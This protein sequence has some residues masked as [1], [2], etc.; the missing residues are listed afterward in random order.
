MNIQ[1]PFTFSNGYSLGFGRSLG[2]RLRAF[3]A[4]AGHF[5]VFLASSRRASLA[6]SSLFRSARALLAHSFV[7]VGSNPAVK[8]IRLRRPAY[9]VR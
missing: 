1:A 3:A 8:P 4:V 2:L 7:A 9:F 6:S 5:L